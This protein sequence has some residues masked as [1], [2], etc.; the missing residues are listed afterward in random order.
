MFPDR[1]NDSMCYTL[2]SLS[3]RP[4]LYR[5]YEWACISQGVMNIVTS[6]SRLLE[7]TRPMSNMA[8]FGWVTHGAVLLCVYHCAASK[9]LVLLRH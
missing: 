9:G 4:S 1:E 8:L 6:V 3:A 5:K 2:T 7:M